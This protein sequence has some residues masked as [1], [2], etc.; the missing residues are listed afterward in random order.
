MKN[1]HV[2]IFFSFQL[3]MHV[4]V[5]HVMEEHVITTALSTLV[6]VRL[7]LLD[8]IVNCVSKITSIDKTI[9]V[10]YNCVM[11]FKFGIFL[12]YL[13]LLQFLFCSNHLLSM[14]RDKCWPQKGAHVFQP[15]TF[16]VMI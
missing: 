4:Q 5:T 2:D 6:P 16:T 11:L 8:P 3:L 15:E 10:C 1:T 7:V 12:F 9:Y 14:N 13:R